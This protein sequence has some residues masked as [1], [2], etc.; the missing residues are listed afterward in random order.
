M[1]YPRF[2]RA[3]SFKYATRSSGDVVITTSTWANIDT[4][5]DLTLNVQVGDVIEVG[6]SG[7]WLYNSSNAFA[8]LDAATLVAGAPVN[9]VAGSAETNVGEGAMA[10]FGENAG[11]TISSPV[12]GSVM[13]AVQAGDIASGKV[14]LR[15]RGRLLTGTTRTLLANT[16]EKLHWW[17]KNLGPVDPN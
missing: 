10:W 7:R 11:G 14:T 16:T 12:G 9:Y 3:R 8:A 1:P 15:L 6:L 5:L 13:Y 2:M 4:G 17:A